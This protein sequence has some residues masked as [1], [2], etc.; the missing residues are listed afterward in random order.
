MLIKP[1]DIESRRKRF[2]A[3]QPPRF[4]IVGRV[5]GNQVRDY[6]LLSLF[7]EYERRMDSR[8]RSCGLAIFENGTSSRR[9]Q[10]HSTTAMPSRPTISL[11][12][13]LTTRVAFGLSR[14]RIDEMRQLCMDMDARYD[15][16]SELGTHPQLCY[17]TK[18]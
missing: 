13:G 14:L 12:A 10:E 7:R 15:Y 17:E 6:Q 9:A 5:S 3:I 1:R 16:S 11:S 2:D 8:S 4:A 18:T